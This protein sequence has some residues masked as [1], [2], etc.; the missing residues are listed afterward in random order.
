LAFCI[1]DAHWRRLA[2][3]TERMAAMRSYIKLL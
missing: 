2:N 1:W 3:T